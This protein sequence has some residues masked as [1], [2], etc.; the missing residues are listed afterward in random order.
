MEEVCLLLRRWETTLPALLFWLE[1]CSNPLPCSSK[2]THTRDCPIWQDAQEGEFLARV[3][4]RLALTDHAGDEESNALLGRDVHNH[5]RLAARLLRHK[6][7]G[8]ASPWAPFIRVLALVQPESVIAGFLLYHCLFL[9]HHQTAHVS[10]FTILC[11][12][13][14]SFC[15]MMLSQSSHDICVCRL[16]HCTPCCTPTRPG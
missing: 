11:L 10:M 13:E 3:P 15:R 9:H 6:A 5:V 2:Q 8:D 7:A 1:Q 14:Q 12:A 4:M 16:R